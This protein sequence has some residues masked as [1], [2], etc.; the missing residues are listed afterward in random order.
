MSTTDMQERLAIL[1]EELRKGA[2]PGC[3]YCIVHEEQPMDRGA[4]GTWS[5]PESPSVSS[6]T[7][8]DV[9]SITK[10]FTAALVLWL[11][12]RRKI[13]IYSKVGEWLPSFEGSGLLITDLLC[14]RAGFGVRL[15]DLR[16]LGADG[17]VAALG[18]IVPP[19][20][21]SERVEYENITYLYLGQIIEAVTG[22]SFRVSMGEFIQT[23]GLEGVYLGD[24]QV[25]IAAPPTEICAGIV[26]EGVVHDESARLLGGL[27][28]NAGIF[29]SA[30]G[31][32]EFGLRWIRGE[33][34]SVECLRTVVLKNYDVTGV[35]PQALGWWMRIPGV[36]TSHS[37]LYSH[38]GYTGC[39]L[40]IRPSTRTVVALTCNRTWYG[41]ENKAHYRLWDGVLRHCL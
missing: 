40:A 29:A 1:D 30:S 26:I 17:F 22:C 33:I 2:S 23:L 27:A 21:R 6:D 5:G 28:G 38:T 34:V 41:R 3:G 11:Y 7:L 31:L 12:E 24:R 35:S 37:G 8:F 4:F 15:G 16:A 25:P 39:L 18:D 9:A 13:D 14:H 36:V 20:V 19:R 32:C 10:V